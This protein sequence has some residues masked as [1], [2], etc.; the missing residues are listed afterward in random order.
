MYENALLKWVRLF[1][2]HV[3]LTDPGSLNDP[4]VGLSPG[5]PRLLHRGYLGVSVSCHMIALVLLILVEAP[6]PVE[7]AAV[8]RNALSCRTASAPARLQRA[9][10]MSM[11]SLTS[12]RQ[13]PLITP[14]ATGKP[15]ARYS[16]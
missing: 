2:D 13:A 10:V 16:S 1:W 12:C 9:P 4:Q 14:V 15:A 5:S 6:V 11:W 3:L 7:V 8:A